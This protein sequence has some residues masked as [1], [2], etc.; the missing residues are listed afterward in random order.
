MTTVHPSKRDA[1]LVAVLI[2]A[3]AVS[4]YAAL[5]VLVIGAPAVAV[6][7]VPIVVTGVGMPLWILCWTRYT[8]GAGELLVR[9]GPFRWR[10]AV[11]DIERVLP[12]SSAISSPALSLDRLR[13]DYDGGK[14]LMISPRNKQQFLDEIEAARR[15]AA[16]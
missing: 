8:L 12:V 15:A 7:A 4:L 3:S 13:I 9:S 16:P 5:S 11:V 1:W 6:I 2:P 10:I 14:S